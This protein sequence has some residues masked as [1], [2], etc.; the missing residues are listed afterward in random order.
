MNWRGGRWRFT[1]STFQGVLWD[2]T[3]IKYIICK[4]NKKKH[5][6]IKK[7]PYLDF[8]WFFLKSFISVD[9][10]ESLKVP[11]T[12]LFLILD[13]VQ[14]PWT[15]I[16]PQNFKDLQTRTRLALCSEPPAQSVASISPSG[17]ISE[18]QWGISALCDVTT[19]Q[20]PELLSFL[21]SL[22]AG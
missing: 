9:Q 21:G 7:I 22:L 15:I 2:I 13:S 5:T 6:S 11:H 16:V 3:H 19:G 12:L 10:L 20:F 8:L 17:R 18:Y 14:Q 4:K 1:I